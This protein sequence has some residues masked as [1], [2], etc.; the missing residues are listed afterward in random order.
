ML[1]AVQSF[2][3]LR[4]GMR[5]FDSGRL[6]AGLDAELLEDDPPALGDAEVIDLSDGN[7]SRSDLP[8][9]RWDM[10]VLAQSLQRP[11]SAS[12]LGP[13]DAREA[14]CNWFAQTG[15]PSDAAHIALTASTSEA[16]SYLFKYCARPGDSVATAVPGYPLVQHLAELEGLQ[17][18]TYSST[19]D[20]S[21]WHLDLHSVQDVLRQGAKILVVTTP[22]NPTGACLSHADACALAQMC[23]AAKALCIFDE[24]FAPYHHATGANGV[25]PWA[26]LAPFERAVSLG[27]MSKA[28]LL[29]QLKLSWI[30]VHGTP[31]FRAEALAALTWIADAYLSVSGPAA[32]AVAPLV[33]SFAALH[34]N[35]RARLRDNAARLHGLLPSLG[36][37]HSLPVQAGWYAPVQL[38]AAVVAAA[39]GTQVC[40][41]LAERAQVALQPGFLFDMPPSCH[42][43]AGLLSNW[44]RLEAGWRRVALAAGCAATQASL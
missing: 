16:F 28:A 2:V 38:S 25:L 3:L 7:A 20:G 5:H 37:G 14:L 41:Y 11:Y 18:L 1:L 30:D 10:D 19:F 12:A 23:N 9:P 26:F 4:F 22:N 31:S 6:P 42:A 40:T 36:I 17:T 39:N 29:P 21:A 44:P 27:G 35:A 43:V 34:A 24:V 8:R 15:R 13:E 32:A 33:G